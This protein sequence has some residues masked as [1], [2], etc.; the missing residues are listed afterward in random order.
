[1]KAEDFQL[2]R[3][4]QSTQG[5]DKNR[6]QIIIG[7]EPDGRVLVVDG[8]AHKVEKPKRKSLKHL[9]GKPKVAED[10]LYLLQQ[11]KPLE[12]YLVKKALLRSGYRQ[13]PQDEKEE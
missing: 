5:R 2:G 1:M 9:K 3:I 6:Y 7:I 4:V 8:E 11:E 10:I 13:N 12:N